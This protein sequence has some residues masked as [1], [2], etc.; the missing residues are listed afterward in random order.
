MV[1]FDILEA[2]NGI[3]AE[4]KERAGDDEVNPESVSITIEG[5][6]TEVLDSSELKKSVEKIFKSEVLRQITNI[7]ARHDG[8]ESNIPITHEYWELTNKY[9]TM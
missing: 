2:L 4:T 1:D 6:L 7:L 3:T 8:L 9:R 5:S